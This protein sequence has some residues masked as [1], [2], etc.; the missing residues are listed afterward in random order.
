VRGS[1]LAF[2]LARASRK[3]HHFVAVCPEPVMVRRVSAMPGLTRLASGPEDDS[4]RGRA[5]PKSS[6][7]REAGRLS[8]V[9]A[10][11][12]V[13]AFDQR[14]AHYEHGWLGRLHAEIAERVAT[15][16]LSMHPAPSHVLDVG[17]GTGYL[18]RVLADRCPGTVEFAG[19]DPAAA[20][21]HAAVAASVDQR[22][23]FQLGVAEH[24]PY[25]QSVFDLVV[26]T[27]SF[28]HWSNQQ[29]GIGECARVLEPGGLFLLAD[30]FSPMLAPTLL[31]SRRAKARTTGRAE[32]LLLAAALRVIS[33]HR[34]YPLIKAV[35]ATR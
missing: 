10:D 1:R 5:D 12:D 27:T 29:I 2:V 19:I 3:T 26:S 7:G 4:F 32:R 30:L 15:L 33:W 20:M 9:P 35:A 28:D 34:V 22:I 18:L 17:C 23:A 13:V 31:A 6:G 24:L 21:V 14:A 25:R 16:A 11:R 8:I